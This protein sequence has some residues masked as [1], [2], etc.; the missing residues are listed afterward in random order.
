MIVPL[1]TRGRGFGAITFSM[2]GSGRTLTSDELDIAM[3]LARRTAGAIDNAV[4]Y[5]RSLELR[6]EA[7]AA[8]N[9]KSEFLAKMSHEIR[10]PINAMMGYAELMQLGISGPVTDQQAKY[11][12]RIRASG[13]HLTSLIGEILDLAKIEAGRMAVE[14][15]AAP[16][17]EAIEGALTIVRPS[18]TAKGVEL[19]ATID[20]DPSSPYFGDPQRVQQIL[21]NLLSNAV[22]FTAA[23]GH[24]GVRVEASTRELPGRGVD[25]EWLAISV[26]DNGVGVA[27]DDRERI[28]HP[29]VQ[30]ESGYTRSQGGTGLGLTISRNLAQLMGGEITVEGAL[31][32]GSTFT[33]WLPCP[34]RALANG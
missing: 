33:L 19:A 22:K 8:S 24:I 4:I 1:V 27:D 7:E 3:E 5:R 14:L 10:T 28:F 25:A 9:A 34:V 29:F 6:L 23:G 13:D 31:G 20:G 12:E 26:I 32:A 30:V 11:L 17:S 16:I 2:A 18:A 21:T 15:T